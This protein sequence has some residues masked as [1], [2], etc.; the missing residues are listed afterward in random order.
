MSDHVAKVLDAA[1]PLAMTSLLVA[2]CDALI[3]WMANASLYTANVD[4]TS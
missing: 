2:A 4:D 1:T 3:P